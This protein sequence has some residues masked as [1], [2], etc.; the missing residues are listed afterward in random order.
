MQ[1]SNSFYGYSKR[2]ELKC[3]D[4]IQ[5]NEFSDSFSMESS[6][7]SHD[8]LH[9]LLLSLLPIQS[10]YEQR[11]VLPQ[12]N[13]RSGSPEVDETNSEICPE[14]KKNNLPYA[15]LAKAIVTL[16]E[17]SVL[18]IPK[19]RKFYLFTKRLSV[20]AKLTIYNYTVYLHGCFKLITITKDKFDFLDKIW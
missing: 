15:I 6:K 19:V 4:D 12:V 7:V 14:W 20:N 1:N 9:S 2:I 11:C 13:D 10:F 5:T 16:R 8:T 17:K 18:N 3:H